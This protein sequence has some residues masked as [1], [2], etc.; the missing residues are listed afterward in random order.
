[1]RQPRFI[2]TELGL[3]L[4]TPIPLSDVQRQAVASYA[5][6]EYRRRLSGLTGDRRAAVV[7][8]ID[9]IRRGDFLERPVPAHDYEREAIAYGR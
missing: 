7:K 2:P 3:V 1:M 6:K 9:A 8:V 5:E 4:E